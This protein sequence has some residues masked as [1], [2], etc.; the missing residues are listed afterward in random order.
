M[1]RISRSWAGLRWAACRAACPSGPGDGHALAGALPD[2]VGLELGDDGEDLQEHPADR[3]LPV[4]DRAAE[5]EPDP[6][7]DSWPRMSSASGTRAGEPVELGDGEG[8]ALTDGGQGLVQ[9]RPGAAGAGQ[10]LVEVDP[11]GGDAE[12]GQGLPLGGEVLGQRWSTA[13]SRC[14]PSG[15]ASLLRLRYLIRYTFTVHPN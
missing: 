7:A 14:S 4:I 12:G 11:V 10:P 8:V 3:V 5:R 9:A 1:R 6:R 13:R 15:P 2:Q